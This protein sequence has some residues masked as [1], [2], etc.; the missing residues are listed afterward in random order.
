MR[1]VLYSG[2]YMNLG[3]KF[4]P[5]M[6]S[7]SYRSNTP[8]MQWVGTFNYRVAYRYPDLRSEKKKKNNR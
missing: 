8:S 7:W 5:Y 6:A 2:Q 4:T 3:S 1:G